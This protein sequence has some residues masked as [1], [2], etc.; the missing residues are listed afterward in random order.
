[1]PANDTRL[2]IFSDDGATVKIGDKIVHGGETQGET[3]PQHLPDLGQSLHF[4]DPSAAGV[5]STADAKVKITVLYSNIK[6]TGGIGFPDVDGCTLFVFG[7]DAPYI[8]D[9]SPNP[10]L[11][12]QG[13]DAT[14]TGNGINLSGLAW[15]SAP[16]GAFSTIGCSRP[17]SRPR[18]PTT[19]TIPARI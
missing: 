8:E 17:T 6:Y 7:D 18:N 3:Q 15:S 19:A 12:A 1:M 11:V 5:G 13:E 16:A 2:A 10:A 9:V 4:I 14:F